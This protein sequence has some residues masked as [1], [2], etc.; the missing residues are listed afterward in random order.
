VA[1]TNDNGAQPARRGITVARRGLTAVVAGLAVAAGAALAQEPD[2]GNFEVRTA[3]SELRGEVY[4]IDALI[5]LRLSDEARQALESGVPLIVH[6]EVDLI[7]VRRFWFDDEEADLDQ[8]FLLEYHTLSERYLVRNLNSG[9][10]ASFATLFSA[11]NFLGR[12]DRLPFIDLALLEPDRAYDARI[13]AELDTD[14][15]PGPLRLLTFWRR[16]FSLSSDW[17][18]WRLQD[19]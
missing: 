12:I 4:F 1:N 17:Y 2:P 13:R 14:E 19:N 3:T 9:D 6:V 5:E 18:R 7:R 16:D 11:L 8:R 15:F 10:Q